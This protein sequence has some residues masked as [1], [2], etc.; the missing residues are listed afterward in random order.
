MKKTR[1]KETNK[2]KHKQHRREPTRKESPFS[3]ILS[4][5][6]IWIK[7]QMK[8]K[9]TYKSWHVPPLGQW[10]TT[11]LRPMQTCHPS[12]FTI[13]FLNTKRGAN[14]REEGRTIL[15]WKKPGR[16]HI[17]ESPQRSSSERPEAGFNKWY[18]SGP[19]DR[20]GS[21]F[22]LW[23]LALWPCRAAWPPCSS[24]Q[25]HWFFPSGLLPPLSLLLGSVLLPICP[26][27]TLPQAGLSS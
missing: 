12:G 5:Y 20:K 3:H 16:S 7:I 13:Q 2:Q 14:G 25:G 11:K 10:L 8:Q 21:L 9:N 1:K 4:F 18:S 6:K 22:S 26:S 27:S 23:F 19:G 24:C 15:L 17:A